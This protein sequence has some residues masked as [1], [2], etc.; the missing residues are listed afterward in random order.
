M[1]LD[2]FWPAMELDLSVKGRGPTKPKGLEEQAKD[3]RA[4][5]QTLVDFFEEA[6]AYA[7]AKDA[8]AAGKASGTDSI[9]AWE[10]MLPYV[11]G[12]LPIMVH[13]DEIR[14]IQAAVAWAATN[15]YKIILAGGRDAWMAAGLLA[16]NQIPV[17]Y[18]HIFEQPVR[19]TESYDVNF[20]APKVLHQAGVRVAFGLAADGFNASSLRNLPY[21][22]AQAVAFGLPDGEALKG[23]SLYPAQLA[24]VSDRLGSLEPGKDATLFAADGDILDIRSNVRRMWVAGREISLET[25]H[26][27]LYERYRNRPKEP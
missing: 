12:N 4:R 22:A 25:R 24:G 16:S 3:R 18:Q 9:P 5:L 13:A 14:Q 7:K 1:A 11:K 27:R 26:T 15:N 6:K 8:A 10:A 20:R 21:A 23:L 19:D 17:V 2:L